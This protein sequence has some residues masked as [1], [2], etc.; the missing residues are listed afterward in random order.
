MTVLRRR[1]TDLAP[2]GGGLAVLGASSYVVLGV[3]GHA[4]APREYAAVASLYL[5]TA[6]VGPGIFV[7]VEQE[8]NRDISTRLAAG[9]GT[10]PVLRGASIVAAGLAGVVTVLLLAL[11]PLLV[12]GVL[13]GSWA[14]FGA[15]VI[16]VVGSAAVYLLRG[17]FAGEQRYGWYAASL[18]GEGGVRIL[19]CLVLAVV[20]GGSTGLFGFVFAVGAGV[21]AL[22]CLPG[23]RSAAHGPPIA[24]RRTAAGIGL[25]A[26]ASGLTFL[27]A[28]LAPLVLT[29][30]LPQAPEVAASFVS[31]FVLAR[32]PVFLFAPLQAF[33]LPSLSAGVERGDPVHV[34]SR[35]RVALCC[36]A[37]VGLPGVLLAGLFGPWAARIFFNAPVDLPAAAAAVLGLS[38]VAMMVAQV[39]QPALVALG[40]HRMA[41]TAWLGGVAVFV[42]LLFVP[43]DPV[44]WAVTA[45]LGGP[46]VVV[47]AMAF[48]VRAALRRLASSRTAVHPK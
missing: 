1:L 32:A 16:A 12:P 43:G 41:T 28:N 26:F 47:V 4:L 3:A 34:R 25:L 37:A 48:S 40:M 10:L 27:V 46:V 31:L 22:L 20:G 15:A 42:G 9:R 7:A 6:I 17:V 13:G 30:R 23:V 45:Q 2:V 38:T 39:L 33:L 14:L 21:A 44:A 29:S 36:V 19:P 5:I 24:L 11:S 8:T 35:L 18:A